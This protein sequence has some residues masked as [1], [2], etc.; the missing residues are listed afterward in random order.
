MTTMVEALVDSGRR[1]RHPA[2][3]ILFFEGDPAHD[4]LLVLEGEVKLERTVADRSMILDVLGPGEWFGEM[5]VLEGGTRSATATTLTATELSVVGATAFTD[6]L[7][8]HPGMVAELLAVTGRRL[9]RTSRHQ[10]ELGATDAMGR[11]CG[12]LVEMA[13][14][15]GRRSVEGVT[16][17]SPLSQADIAAWAGISRES[18]VKSLSTLRELGWVR[19]RGRRL[20]LLELDAGRDRGGAAA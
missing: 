20:T 12:R 7:G 16:I 10:A 13:E 15:Y 18:V 9:A 14:R 5:G 17:R 11:V 1:R 6:L 19:T 2:G 3:S 8:E 4:V